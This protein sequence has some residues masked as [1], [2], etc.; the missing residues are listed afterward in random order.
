MEGFD[1]RKKKSTK[2]KKPK[3]QQSKKKK[4][5]VP[6]KDRKKLRK[7]R[8]EH[9]DP[10]VQKK[11]DAILLLSYLYCA[12]LVALITG[13]TAITIR[14][15][16]TLYQTGGIKALL[17]NNHKGQ[18]SKLHN[19]SSSI[20]EDF[21]KNPPASIAEAQDRIE[22]RTGIKR[23]TRSIRDFLK[24]KL[25]LRYRKV[26]AIPAKA[27]PE[28][29][30]L[31]LKTKLEP[32]LEAAKLGL[33]TV[34]FMD[35]AHFVHMAVLGSLWSK[36]R[37]FIPS[38]SGRRR[39][40][41]LGVVNAI[42]KKISFIQNETYINAMTV[43]ELL[44]Q[45]AQEYPNQLITICLDNASYQKCVL[46]M[47]CAKSLNIELLFLPTYSPN[48]NLIERLW[49]FTRKKCLNSMYYEKFNHFRTAILDSL[50]KSN[51]VWASEL[52]SLL[53]LKFQRFS[54]EK[55]GSAA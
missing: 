38:P 17:K 32:Y 20:E 27:N 33:R 6:N 53:E 8:Y 42:T 52:V 40:N 19:H 12:L 16:R 9:P 24:N 14:N 10:N 18:V 28:K 21:K 37:V 50:E 43:C 23:C 47:E 39:L 45:I 25:K 1:Q 35:A 41:I 34:L 15:Y 31:F 3:K 13:V 26:G 29:Q 49:K 2:K 51:G 22:K 36:V 46:V 5:K 48:L 54:R 7:L 30:E 11:C 44:K 4:F 55:N